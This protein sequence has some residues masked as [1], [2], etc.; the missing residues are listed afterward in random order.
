MRLATQ[1][2][3]LEPDDGARAVQYRQV[4]GGHSLLRGPLPEPQLRPVSP[5][6]DRLKTDLCSGNKQSVKEVVA[7]AQALGHKVPDSEVEVLMSRCAFGLSR[8]P[9][10]SF[11]PSLNS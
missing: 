1:E 10:P 6:F 7:V 9:L 11:H 4:Y 5:Y 3:R 8:P 2:R